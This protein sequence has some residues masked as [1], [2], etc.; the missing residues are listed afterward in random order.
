MSI[1]I[2]YLRHTCSDLQNALLL[3]AYLS[4]FCMCLISLKLLT[5]P[6]HL[7]VLGFNTAVIL[8]TT[9]KLWNP[10][11]GNLLRP[12]VT[13]I[14]QTSS[15][16]VLHLGRELKFYTPQHNETWKIKREGYAGIL[17]SFHSPPQLALCKSIPPPST[18]KLQF[19]R[20][21]NLSSFIHTAIQ[22][23]FCNPFLQFQIPL[24]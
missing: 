1:L 16:C 7:T 13:S 3:S 22:C 20:H 12:P 21:F 17:W 23:W 14:S 5:Y 15:I 8:G 10:S 2:L 24:K 4:K 18:V 6:S 11:I 9:F 19:S